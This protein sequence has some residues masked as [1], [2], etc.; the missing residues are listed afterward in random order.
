[1]AKY[2]LCELGSKSLLRCDESEENIDGKCMCASGASNE[3]RYFALPEGVAASNCKVDLTEGVYSLVEDTS[4]EGPM[5]QALRA[6]RNA[7]LLASDWTQLVD[8][9]LSEQDKAA[10]SAYR[11]DLR[12]LPADSA[13]VEVASW[14]TEPA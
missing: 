8:S 11:Q 10:W 1:M 3:Q 2:W 5:W 7:K 13:S 12:D 6:E 14:P 9:P 4:K